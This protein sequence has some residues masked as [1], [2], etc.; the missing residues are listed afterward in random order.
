MQQYDKIDRSGVV[1][2]QDGLGV[3]GF[4]NAGHGQGTRVSL[5]Y[6]EVDM[7]VVIDHRPGHISLI[8]TKNL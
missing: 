4:D 8:D 7:G 6:L 5:D 2:P 3:E 1:K